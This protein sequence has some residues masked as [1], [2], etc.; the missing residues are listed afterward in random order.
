MKAELKKELLR[1]RD[2]LVRLKMGSTENKVHTIKPE[3]LIEVIL[4]LNS[5][6]INAQRVE[7]WINVD[8]SNLSVDSEGLKVDGELVNFDDIVVDDEDEEPSGESIFGE[9]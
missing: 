4:Y 3:H 2:F 7:D 6:G 8:D 1:I 5:K 9:V